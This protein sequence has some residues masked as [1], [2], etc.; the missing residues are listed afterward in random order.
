[1]VAMEE[2]YAA[3]ISNHTWELVDLPDNK[4]L[5]SCKWVF[6]LKTDAEGA[7][8]KYKA[9]LVARGF[10]Q[11]YGVDYD[12]V[13]APVARH[14]TFRVLLSIAAT[15]EMMAYHVDA[16]SAF[17]NGELEED[18]YMSQPPGFIDESNEGKVC[19]LKKSIYGLKQSAR[20]W[21]EK[22]HKTLIN[23]GMIQAEADSCLYTYKGSQ[24]LLFLL[25]Y[26]DDILVVSKS[27]VYVESIEK[28]LNKHFKIEN[29]GLVT[30]YLGIR[31]TKKENA[32]YLDQEKYIHSIA[33]QFELENSKPVEIPL[34]PAYHKEM[35][36]DLLPNN[37]KY[38]AAIG[39]LLYVSTNTRP[40]VSAAVSILSQKV[41]KPTNNDWNQVKKLIRY[42]KSTSTL[43][44]KLGGSQS[45]NQLTGYA[46]ANWAEDRSNAKSN[47]GYVFMLKGAVSWI[48][49]RQDCVSL[50]STESEFIALSEACKESVWLQR[51]LE[52]LHWD[53]NKMT[54]IYEDNQSVIK[55]IATEK[56]ST[57]TKHINTK[58][59]FVK[60][61]VDKGLVT[62]EYRPTEQM[63]ADIFTKG[64]A[65]DKF[66][67]F[68][69]QLHLVNIA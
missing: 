21:N 10:S 60:D 43:R 67:M 31:V 53:G 36:G 54:L 49:K 13:F 25:V 29:L 1:M 22:L 15:N 16:K 62:I 34:S 24:G 68:R 35:E 41:S 9:R 64:L 44:L 65:K 59:Y 14:C 52:D 46:D 30:N 38:R 27:P 3:L 48:C 12:Q 20:V 32:F 2:E 19:H 6:K 45:A 18:I 26:V 55:L 28:M 63:L 7:V 56:L 51:L 69:K 57:R 42:L 66:E 5:V 39:C 17:L 23:A 4:N 61:Y 33:R 50:S 8:K 37:S 47:S 11:K 58:M 40:D